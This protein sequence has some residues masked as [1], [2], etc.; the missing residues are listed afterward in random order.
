[1]TSP[2]APAVRN[3]KAGMLSRN[4]TEEA[5]PIHFGTLLETQRAASSAPFA[6]Y[7]TTL[8]SD[9]GYRVLQQLAANRI[10]HGNPRHGGHRQRR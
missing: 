5:H 6:P 7:P 1:M 2:V 4:R 10:D 8:Q 9:A 3:D